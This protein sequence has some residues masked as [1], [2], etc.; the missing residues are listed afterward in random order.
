M[1]KSVLLEIAVIEA[2]EKDTDLS[3][4]M[5]G[6]PIELLMATGIALTELVERCPSGV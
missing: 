1:P 3:R 2:L 4:Q 6:L 5:V